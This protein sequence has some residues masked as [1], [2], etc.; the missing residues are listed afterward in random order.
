MRFRVAAIIFVFSC[1][2]V[3]SASALEPAHSESIIKEMMGRV[4]T[5]RPVFTGPRVQGRQQVHDTAGAVPRVT[6]GGV[7]S[8]PAASAPN[9]AQKARIDTGAAGLRSSQTASPRPLAPRDK[10]VERPNGGANGLPAGLRGILASPPQGPRKASAVA[11]DPKVRAKALFCMD[12]SSNKVL[13]AH[14]VCEPLPIAS[15]TKLL[16]AMTVID[17]MN[18]ETVLEVPSDVR[19]IPP[20]RVGLRPGDLLTV[21]D[22]LHGLLI[23]SGNDCAEVLAR[24]YPKGGWHGFMRAMERKAAEVGA[25]KTTIYTPSGLDMNLTLGRRNGRTLAA[26]K[27]NVA[28]AEDV[29]AIARHAFSY[30]LI[31]KIS[32]TKSYTART[33]N[34]KSR[35]YV[36]RSNDRLL[37]RSLPVEGAKT[38]YTNL[39]GRCIVALFKDAKTA[40]DYVVVVLNSPHHFKA[41]EKI[42]HWACKAF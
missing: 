24:A 40:K 27:P 36:L 7:R 35:D 22:L 9:A 29:A 12:S 11:A 14:N 32:G 16:T 15:I 21:R 34:E 18:L 28:S 33:R 23:E 26:K 2:S 30:P 19:E 6:S 17:E 42:Y 13:L 37:D 20:H 1:L 8:V 39:A 4:G 38:G 5:G 41:A 10:A 31:R 25:T 3:G